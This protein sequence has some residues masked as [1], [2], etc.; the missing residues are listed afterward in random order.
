[1]AQ[2]EYPN[3]Q[4]RLMVGF[5]AG[6]STDI[7]ART[8][9]QEAR[10][11]LGQEIIVINKPGATG[12]LAVIDVVG[13]GADGYTL[14]LTPSSPLTLAHEF[15]NIRRD[16]LESTD[17]LITVGRQRIGVAVKA[18]SDIKDF[19]EFIE[20]ARREPGKL[21]L[22][23][24]GSGT[25]T[26]LISRAVFRDAG[27]DVN[28]VPFN[29]DSPLATAILGGHVVAGS[30]AAG[31]WNPLIQAGK[32]RLL[33]SQEQERAEVAPD[34]PTLI[35]LGYSYKGD[36]IQYM[37]GPKGLPANVRKKLIDVFTAAS[38]AKSYVDIAKQNALYDPKLI[39]GEA[40]DAYLLK[41]R[42]TNRA[43][44]QKLGL[45]KQ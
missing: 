38:Q 20:R 4:I 36:A 28:I 10:A 23:I 1:L 14:G 9:A 24:P 13:S 3:R 21:S 35:E 16:L 18:D 15:Q 44:V 34:V 17:A 45:A 7:L 27:V 19:K 37:Y 33:V 25:M 26:D 29:G 11:A 6:G 30:F 8:I 32:L 42:A 41:D 31:G 2:N 5:P 22:G 40:L 43:L 39:A 12:A